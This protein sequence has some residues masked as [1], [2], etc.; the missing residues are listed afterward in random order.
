MTF[1]KAS[2]AISTFCNRS[3]LVL[4]ICCCWRDMREWRY[5]ACDPRKSSRSIVKPLGFYNTQHTHVSRNDETRLGQNACIFF[6]QENNACS[7]YLPCYQQRKQKSQTKI[8]NE[9]SSWS[10]NLSLSYARI[11]PSSWLS[12]SYFPLSHWLTL[13][14]A[15]LHFPIKIAGVYLRLLILGLSHWMI[16]TSSGNEG[17]S[18]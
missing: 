12:L 10:R 6:S 1:L 3:R 2:S 9:Q 17:C 5:W 18:L 11:P 14:N 4:V 8:E 15:S 13:A 16:L 7:R